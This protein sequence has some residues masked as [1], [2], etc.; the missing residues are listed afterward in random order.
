MTDDPAQP[1]FF[2]IKGDELYNVRI[3]EVIDG[4]YRV[5][6][7]AGS[8]LRL[9]YLPLDIAQLLPMGGS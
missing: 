1:V 3:G 8:S 5:D 4:T 2:L 7:I 9:V 6:S